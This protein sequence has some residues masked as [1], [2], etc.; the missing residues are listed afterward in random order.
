MMRQTVGPRAAAI[1]AGPIGLMLIGWLILA[2][3]PLQAAAQERGGVGMITAAAGQ[4]RVGH[5]AK[6]GQAVSVAL[7]PVKIGQPVFLH[8]VIETQAK[9]RA[10][11]LFQDDSIL[12]VAEKTRLEITEAMYDPAQGSR[13][14]VLKLQEGKV[15]AIIS[16]FLTGGQ[17]KFEIHT[18]TTVAAAR[19]TEVIVHHI[20]P[21][22]ITEP[23]RTILILIS[24]SL[25]AQSTDEKIVGTVT[26][27]PG[28][29]VEVYPSASLP[30][31]VPVPPNELRQL[32]RDTTVVRP[33]AKEEAEK[34]AAEAEARA[35]EAKKKEEE[36][37]KKE[38][39]AKKK[40]EQAKAKEQ[41][42]ER[43]V[44]EAKT[45]EEEAKI[46]EEVAEAKVETEK[47]EAAASEAK[48]KVTDATRGAFIAAFHAEQLSGGATLG[49]V[50]LAGGE[51]PMPSP[52]EMR[53]MPGMAPPPGMMPM[54]MDLTTAIQTVTNVLTTQTIN[55]LTQLI[56]LTQTTTVPT[57]GTTGTTVQF[58]F[59]TQ[60]NINVN[61]LFP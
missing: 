61:V 60:S 21:P 47:T 26:L 16:R 45:K 43:K 52:G 46:K 30:P 51:L 8:D 33:E 9:S 27:T 56:T 50:R 12:N 18:P 11:I 36:A 15:R 39:E 17:S 25:L 23:P 29:K 24:G 14:S 22:V 19:G 44:A 38:E 31:P 10:Q 40:A 28:T 48:A 32:L 55:P 49:E 35:G 2:A 53:I 6:P 42:A 20:V 58:L 59:P 1:L 4:V 7:T 54:T 37:K 57:T 13:Q 5:Q 41:E 34:R 3:L